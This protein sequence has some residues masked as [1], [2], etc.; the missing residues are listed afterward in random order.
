MAA[1][2]TWQQIQDA[3]QNKQSDTCWVVVK[4]KIYDITHYLDKHP[5][6]RAA[7]EMSK[8]QDVTWLLETSH[9]FTR[10]PWKILESYYIGELDDVSFVEYPDKKDPLWE[11][12]KMEVKD[13]FDRTGLDE[14]D[15]T[16]TIMTALFILSM[17]CTGYYFGFTQG[18]WYGAVLFGVSRALFGIH[19]MH[20]ASHFSVTH[21]PWVWRWLDWLAFDVFMGGSSLAWNYQHVLG[22]HQHT[23][24]FQADPDLPV[25]KKGDIRRVVP[26]QEDMNYYKYQAYYLP[27][28]YTLLALKTRIYDAQIIMGERMNGVLKMTVSSSDWCWLLATKIFFVYYQFYLPYFEFNLDAWT[29]FKMYVFAELASGA[30]LAYFFQVNHISDE[31]V[32]SVASEKGDRQQGWA[33]MQI[34]GTVDY[35]H[36]SKLTTFLSGTLNYQTVHHLFPSVSTH[37]YP[38]IAPIIKRVCMKHKVK[39]NHVDTFF[40]AAWLHLKELNRLGHLG[41]QAHME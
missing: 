6:G 12:L 41:I 36:D 39:Y 11:E 35:G 21:Q 19:T 22:H 13:Y 8:G 29:L 26:F 18:A 23:N 9:P 10:Q 4:N 1:K 32:Y 34:E 25:L 20:S 37:H 16:A 40:E 38:A 5:G 15:P 2:Y 14:K 27:L 24:V 30:W 17:W 28:L 33:T 7:L 31:L 3:N